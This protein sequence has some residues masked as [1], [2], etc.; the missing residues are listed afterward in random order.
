MILTKPKAKALA[1]Q[2][3]TAPKTLRIGPA[4]YDIEY[5]ED[6]VLIDGDPN[7]K[8]GMCHPN[9]ELIKISVKYL[10]SPVGLVSVFLH[11]ALHGIWH[12]QNLPSKV[13]EEEAVQGIETG[14]V[15]LFRSNPGLIDW[16]KKGLK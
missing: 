13:K 8:M 12:N 14:L 5:V 3:N 4:D 6:G 10:A 16:I 9:A 11:E 1:N 7:P 2:L 15:Q